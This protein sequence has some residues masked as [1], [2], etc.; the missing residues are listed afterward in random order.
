[1]RKS[2]LNRLFPNLWL[3]FIFGLLL[4]IFVSCKKNNP[5]SSKR[6][7]KINSVTPAKGKIGS[8]VRIQGKN[9]SPAKSEDAVKFGPQIAAIDSASKKELEVTVPKGLYMGTSYKITVTVGGKTVTA[10][11]KF[12]VSG[13]NPPTDTTNTAPPV[14][15][16][17]EAVTWNIEYDSFGPSNERLQMK[18]I[19]KAADSLHADLYALEEVKD[20]Q[21]LEGFVKRMKGYRGIFEKTR[22]QGNAFI[23]NPNVIDPISSG[24][25][26]MDQLSHPW[27]GRLPFY[28]SF[29]YKPGKGKNPVKIYAVVI[30]A[31]AGASRGDYKRRVTAAKELYKYLTNERPH[32]RIILLGDYND[33]LNMSI[34]KGHPSSYKIFVRDSTHYNPLTLVLAKHHKTSE[35]NYQSVI[36]NIIIS[37]EMEKYYKPGSVHVFI[38]TDD[39][40]K[41]Y[42][43]T[44]SDHYPVEALFNMRR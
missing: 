40:I 7:P 1:M 9:F 43:N 34:Y 14:D 30:H 32:A 39:F 3:L 36:D 15:G 31:K 22:N 25:I 24:K 26:T 13:T 12:T 29:N 10:S 2:N 4:A 5:E 18:N 6:S 17:L 20:K 11:D 37:N 8:V 28:F 35:V 44:T 41:D 33:K 38:P 42:G 19:V 23:Y 21:A 27:A 16:I